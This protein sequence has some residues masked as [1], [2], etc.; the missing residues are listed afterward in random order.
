MP[1]Y[2]QA[3]RPIRVDTALGKDVL[4]LAGFSGVESVSQPFGFELDLMSLKSDVD[5]VA[6]LRNPVL[7]TV[8]RADGEP[9]LIHGLAS[10]LTQLGM[11]DDLVFYRARVV[12]WLLSEFSSEAEGQRFRFRLRTHCIGEFR[13]FGEERGTRIT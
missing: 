1:D 11:Q 12:P 2:T 13:R 5:P 10:R 6:F 4:L 3:N 8:D 7:I 9:R